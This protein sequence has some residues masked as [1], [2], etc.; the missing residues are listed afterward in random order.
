MNNVYELAALWDKTIQ[1]E[2]KSFALLHQSLYPGLFNYA[3]KMLKD[4]DLVDDLLQDLFIKFWQ[5]RSHI[6]SI[7]NVKSYFYRSTRSIVLNH[8]KSS[9]LKA[10]KLENMPELDFEFSKEELILAD[11]VDAELKAALIKALNQLPPK[12]KEVVYMHFYEGLQYNQISEVTGTRYQS[13]VNT[14]HRAVQVLR[15]V[16]KLKA[17]YV[18]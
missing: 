3:L 7:G 4:E 5:N 2:E 13:V 14:V 12:Q 9:Q 8:I 6:G 17:I 1:G 18:V 10:S 16:T 11:E 15:E